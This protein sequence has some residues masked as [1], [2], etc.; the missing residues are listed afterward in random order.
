[1]KRKFLSLILFVATLLGTVALGAAPSSVTDIAAAN[2]K[3]DFLKNGKTEYKI[4]YD[5]DISSTEVVAVSEFQT[6]FYDGTGSTIETVYADEVTLDT[7]AKYICVGENDYSR[8]AGLKADFANLASNGY[9]IK[10]I[11]NNV[12]IIGGGEWGT[13]WGVYDFL[14][15]QIGYE[16]IYTDELVFDEA[17]CLNGKIVDVDKT[18]KP[19]WEWRVVGD[20]ENSNNKDLRTRL[21]MHDNS[22]VWTTNG[23]ISMFHTFFSRE[24]TTYG[25]VP[26][27]PCFNEHRNWYNVDY[28]NAGTSPS[29]L[30]FSRDP[31][32]LCE[33]IMKGVIDL[34]NVGGN[35]NSI[36]I[37]FSQLDNG[38]WCFCDKCKNTMNAYGGA[39]SATQ[40][41]FMKNYLSPA[42]KA[43]TDANCPEMDVTIYMYAYWTT[44]Q[45]PKFT[46]DA[47]LESLKLPS[48]CGVQYC[49]GFPEKRPIPQVGE[50][51]QAEAWA[52]ISSKFA[53]MDYAENFGSYLRHF[54]DYNKLQPNL[55]YF[56][57]HGGELHYTMMA[58]NNLANSDWSRLHAYLEAELSWD[59]NKDVNV[60]TDNF[61]DKYYKDAAP[62]MKEW[63]YGY[64]AWSQV[65]DSNNA[66]GGTVLP[67]NMCKAFDGYANKAYDAI[68][69]Y[70][71]SDPE[72]YDKL[73]DRITLETLTYRYNYLESYRGYIGDLKSFAESFRKDCAHFGIQKVRES[74][75]FDVWYSQNFGNL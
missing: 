46:T 75:N 1:M 36:I 54:D 67:L 44:K 62:F 34:I 37:N 30:C 26:I 71:Y 61:F 23:N 3:A 2:E 63:F 50:Y 21:R 5:R 7:N 52:K 56:L 25:F 14:S 49:T 66:Q 35:G 58:Y 69:K 73:Y 39:Q 11:N 8:A 57:K 59:V 72:L 53:I 40:V 51:S 20:G 9:A 32:G 48:N 10:T 16:F 12:F 64:R 22:N 38:D 60:L 18:E 45:P 41:L 31:E 68:L 74:T 43:Y 55:E 4:V 6:L 15:L 27:N 33:Q 13:I 19:D 47:E 70:K 17:K 29:A 28:E 65:F 42:L 24:N